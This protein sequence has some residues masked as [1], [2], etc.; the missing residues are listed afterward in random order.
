M[1]PAVAVLSGQKKVMTIQPDLGVS[2]RKPKVGDKEWRLSQPV[3][4]QTALAE[5][6]TG[7]AHWR[8][9]VTDSQCDLGRH[10]CCLASILYSVALVFMGQCM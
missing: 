2:L 5:G 6:S 8:P 9:Q 3:R 4:P 10:P 7:R 1:R